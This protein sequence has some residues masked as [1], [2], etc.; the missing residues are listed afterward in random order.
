MPA[1]T[2]LYDLITQDPDMIEILAEYD[3]GEPE[4]VPA[5]YIGGTIPG[6][7]A[8]PAVK[9]NE[10][11]ANREGTDRKH[12][13]GKTSIDIALWW[14]KIPSNKALRDASIVL[15]KLV[16]RASLESSATFELPSCVCSIPSYRV[17]P[18]GFPGYVTNALIL[19]REI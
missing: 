14:P 19:V 18:D 17:D 1:I 7:M 13:G 9:L 6:D 10:I 3:N 15:W 2:A 12:R 5:V 11:D 8:L 16:N 4:L